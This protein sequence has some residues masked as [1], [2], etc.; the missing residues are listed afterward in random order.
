[1]KTNFERRWP[2]DN[3][4]WVPD[5]SYKRFLE[6]YPEYIVKGGCE[7][8]SFLPDEFYVKHW[9]YCCSSSPICE[10][11]Y[12]KEELLAELE[13]AAAGDVFEVWVLSDNPKYFMFKCPDEN[14]L[15]PL[16][17]AY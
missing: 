1:M 7:D 3:R 5:E 4:E 6:W 9:L 15:V 11:K 8:Y 17:G 14:G 10:I 13:K 12:E 2:N 16:K